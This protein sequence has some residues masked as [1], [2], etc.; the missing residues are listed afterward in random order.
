MKNDKRKSRTAA[1]RKSSRTQD[2]STGGQQAKTG[3]ST[4]K[5]SR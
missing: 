5:G 1:A 2:K 3:K 4:G